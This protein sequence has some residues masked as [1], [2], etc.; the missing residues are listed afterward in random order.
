MHILHNASVNNPVRSPAQGTASRLSPSAPRAI[1]PAV[2]PEPY[3]I[4]ELTRLEQFEALRPEWD[5][6]LTRAEA[7]LFQTWEWQWSWWRH[8][9][10]GRLCI[11]TARRGGELVGIAPLMLGR[12]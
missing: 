4:E 11:M 5:A 12:Y 2:M 3:Q 7:S 6:L 1:M 8:F 10:R 9:G